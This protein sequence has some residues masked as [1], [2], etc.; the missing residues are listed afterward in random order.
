METDVINVKNMGSQEDAEKILAALEHVW[1]LTKA[2]V[3]LSKK[4]AIVTFDERMASS[5]DFIQAIVETG[6]DI[7]N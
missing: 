1:G 7:S 4:E 3:S 2:E 6:F 5:Q